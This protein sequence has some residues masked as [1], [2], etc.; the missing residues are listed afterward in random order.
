MTIDLG[1]SL[2]NKL[3]SYYCG[4]N[5]WYNF[6]KGT[7][8]GCSGSDLSSG[9]GHAKNL[10]L[11][12]ESFH[13]NV[14]SVTLGPY[15]G[16]VMGAITL[17]DQADCRGSSARLYWVPWDI[18]GGQYI[19]DDLE[20][21]GMEDNTVSSIQVPRGYTAILYKHDGF[22]EE[23]ARVT[24]WYENELTQE[25]GC[26]NILDVNDVVSSVRIVK[27]LIAVGYW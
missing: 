10:L 25:L 23:V 9:A 3:S 20:V 12:G 24:G 7:G 11:D 27:D 14:E 18:D 4:K 8:G 15:D 26:L 19:L 2:S 17:F 16:N 22:D 5:V 21:A 13:D 6:C 1:D